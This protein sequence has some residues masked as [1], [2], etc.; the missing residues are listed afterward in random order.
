MTNMPSHLH[1]LKSDILWH[2]LLYF[3]PANSKFSQ[4]SVGEEFDHWKDDNEDDTNYN[5]NN[6]NHK[7]VHKEQKNS[8][9][10][11]FLFCHAWR[12]WLVSCMQDLFVIFDFWLICDIVG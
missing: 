4:F 8:I 9:I 7:N 11:F 2:F 6:N 3:L 10:F 12:D 1:R 5:N